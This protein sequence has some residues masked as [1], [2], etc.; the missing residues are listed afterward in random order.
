M[1]NK[2]V[3]LWNRLLA[4]TFWRAVFWWKKR[5]GWKDFNKIVGATGIITA[6]DINVTG[7][8]NDGDICFNVKLDAGQ[9]WM[10]TVPTTGRL[11]SEDGNGPS[12][13]C[14]ITPWDRP[15][16][17]GKWQQ[18]AV[19]KRVA[20]T[21]RWGFDGVHVVGMPEWKQ[22][23]RGLWYGIWGTLQPSWK[24]GWYEIHPVQTLEFI[25]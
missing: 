20:V 14:E 24:D 13:H 25:P 3:A 8:F 22:V 1:K 2:I 21:G 11:T 4:L 9:E 5:I 7:P 16:F 6:I 18:L 15:M 10:V 17:E 19:G 12:L 23:L